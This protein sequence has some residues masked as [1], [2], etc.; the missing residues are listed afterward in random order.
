MPDPN[1]GVGQPEVLVQMIITY[2]TKTNET[3]L[4]APDPLWKE[5]KRLARG[6]LATA[7]DILEDREEKLVHKANLIQLPGGLH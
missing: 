1:N 7:R 5:H 4:T 2:N 3:K 6:M